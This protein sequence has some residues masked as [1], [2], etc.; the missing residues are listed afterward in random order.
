MLLHTKSVI[1]EIL[2]CVFPKPRVTHVSR[3]RKNF[4][5]KQVVRAA[6]QLSVFVYVLTDIS[7]D[8]LSQYTCVRP[9]LLGVLCKRTQQC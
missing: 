4:A 2:T 1:L 9:T 6:P 8:T 5:N 7:M 3:G